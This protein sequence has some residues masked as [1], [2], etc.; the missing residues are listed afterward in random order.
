MTT[1]TNTQAQ[2]QTQNRDVR[3]AYFRTAEKRMLTLARA[4]RD[5]DN[6]T[7][8]MEVGFALQNPI[9]QHSKELARTIASGRLRKHPV[10]VDVTEVL[11]SDDEAIGRTLSMMA[12]QAVLNHARTNGRLVYV[13]DALEEALDSDEL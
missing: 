6:G 4:L 2:T 13:E 7:K 10:R 1:Q 5:A 9:D 3:F 11:N 12:A 8:V